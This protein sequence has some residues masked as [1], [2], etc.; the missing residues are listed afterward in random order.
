MVAVSGCA[1]APTEAGE[2]DVEATME[3]LDSANEI[4]AKKKAVSIGDAWEVSADGERVGE[5]I[6]EMVH[7]GRD[8]YTYLISEES[9]SVGSNAGSTIPMSRFEDKDRLMISSKN[10]RRYTEEF[11]SAQ[12]FRDEDVNLL[13]EEVLLAAREYGYTDATL[14]DIKEVEIDG[15]HLFFQMTSS[16]S[17]CGYNDQVFSNVVPVELFL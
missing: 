4:M 3:Q 11:L 1:V 13:K 14:E 10:V 2:N 6:G 15:N 17:G 9:E 12:F 16:M 5:V 8:K 7:D